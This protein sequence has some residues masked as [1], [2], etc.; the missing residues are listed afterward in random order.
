MRACKCAPARSGLPNSPFIDKNG[1]GPGVR[2]RERSTNPGT[3]ETADGVTWR[4]DRCGA[5]FAV[6]TLKKLAASRKM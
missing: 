4:N 5:E 6:D 3:W 2:L 1:G